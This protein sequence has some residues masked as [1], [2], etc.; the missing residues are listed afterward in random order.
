[1]AA[2]G[3]TESSRAIDSAVGTETAG[4]GFW[5]R[6]FTSLGV[7]EVSGSQS[8]IR[9]DGSLTERKILFKQRKVIHW[10]N[11]LD[12]CFCHPFSDLPR[13]EAH[14]FISHTP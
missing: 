10:S 12:V 7:P 6:S 11:P 8:I 4:L 13:E 3:L 1:M 9:R 5:L 14:D 2:F